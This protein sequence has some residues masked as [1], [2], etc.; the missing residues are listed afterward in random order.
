MLAVNVLHQ[1][2]V[3]I[4]V[5]LLSHRATAAAKVLRG[6]LIVSVVAQA[7]VETGNLRVAVGW[8]RG[9]EHA[10]HGAGDLRE[11]GF[12]GSREMQNEE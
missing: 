1:V 4:P 6:H 10:N 7:E 12:V 11:G 9:A 5:G 8:T 3:A 2:R